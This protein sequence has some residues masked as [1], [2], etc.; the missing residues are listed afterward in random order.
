MHSWTGSLLSTLLAAE[1]A[2]T[3][4]LARRGRRRGAQ[5][6]RGFVFSAS[7]RQLWAWSGSG[8]GGVRRWT[9]SLLLRFS[10]P[11]SGLARRGGGGAAY[12]TRGLLF[13]IF[14][15]RHCF[16]PETLATRQ[17]IGFAT[18]RLLPSSSCRITADEGLAGRTGLDCCCGW[19]L[20]DLLAIST[21]LCAVAVSGVML[22]TVPDF[23][24]K[25]KKRHGKKW[26][27][28]LRS[29]PGQLA[30]RE[31]HRRS[32][33]CCC[34]KPPLLDCSWNICTCW[35]VSVHIWSQ[36]VRRVRRLDD[37]LLPRRLWL[38]G[39]G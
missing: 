18:L 31:R 3:S 22:Q 14:G 15:S 34:C 38:A 30:R 9:G 10:P 29:P 11:T 7:R 13:N 17:D 5:L 28:T 25:I 21:M 2:P 36:N 6:D 35:F 20:L 39:R 23:H 8:G 19:L 4:G 24:K 27:D 16:G 37:S 32:T 1:S 12:E 33:Y 26:P